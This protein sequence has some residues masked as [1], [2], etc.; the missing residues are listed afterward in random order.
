MEL[1][2]QEVQLAS[3]RGLGSR[4]E[5]GA[6]RQVRESQRGVGILKVKSCSTAVV[7]VFLSSS[8]MAGGSGGKGGLSKGR[9]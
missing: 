6:Q 2:G 5:S 7:T 3:G 4:G 1:G 9:Q 8:A